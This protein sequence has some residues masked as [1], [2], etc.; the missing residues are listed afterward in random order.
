MDKT[1]DTITYKA[2]WGTARS[3]V[4]KFYHFKY[5]TTQNDF[6]NK[7]EAICKLCGTKTPYSG[8]T[9]NL[10]FHL[11]KFHYAERYG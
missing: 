11:N 9:T 4:W 5:C 7:K 1:D 10:S 3:D 2:F 6:V 8:N